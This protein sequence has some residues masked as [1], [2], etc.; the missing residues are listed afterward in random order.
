[1]NRKVTAPAKSFTIPQ[2]YSTTPEDRA[3]FL[4]FLRQFGQF[5]E[6][7]EGKPNIWWIPI[8]DWDYTKVSLH[9]SDDGMDA[10][11]NSLKTGQF[12]GELWYK[13]ESGAGKDEE[14]SVS[15]TGLGYSSE[16]DYQIW[17]EE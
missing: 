10:S 13:H 16:A 11:I 12:I 6:P 3:R 17:V 7:I 15:V 1:M 9:H 5:G 2:K 14:Y 4:N 8:Q